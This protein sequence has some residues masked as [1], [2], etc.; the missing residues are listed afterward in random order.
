MND[1]RY[2]VAAMRL[3][4]IVGR[5]FALRENLAESVLLGH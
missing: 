2:H 3:E 5:W 1:L 4:R